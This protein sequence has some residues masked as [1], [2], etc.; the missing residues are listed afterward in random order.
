MFLNDDRLIRLLGSISKLDLALFL[1]YAKVEYKLDVLE[2]F[3]T[4]V[5]TAE[6]EPI[7][8]DY[9]QSDGKSSIPFELY[10]G[11]IYNRR[12]HGLHI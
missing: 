12:R 10:K 5:P 6:L 7:T 11:L 1:R 9:T 2:K 8:E 3:L 4:A